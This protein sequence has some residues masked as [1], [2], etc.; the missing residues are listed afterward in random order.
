MFIIFCDVDFSDH[1]LMQ[2]DLLRR[3]ERVD[4]GPRIRFAVFCS[5]LDCRIWPID[6][7]KLASNPALCKRLHGVQQTF[8]GPRYPLIHSLIPLTSPLIE[9]RISHA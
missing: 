9:S 3:D 6:P 2:G 5:T 7:A 4:M 8:T 1:S